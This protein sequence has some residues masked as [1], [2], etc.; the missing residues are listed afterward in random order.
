MVRVVTAIA[1]EFWARYR[2]I[3]QGGLLLM[4]GMGI[5]NWVWLRHGASHEAW[6]RANYGLTGIVLFLVYGCFHGTEEGQRSG[7]RAFP[8]RWFV[9][10]LRTGVLVAWPMILGVLSIVFVYSG[11]LLL[12][13]MPYGVRAPVVWPCLYLSA[14]LVFYQGVLWCLPE[15]RYLKLFLLSSFATVLAI[16]WMFFRPDLLAGTLAEWELAIDV[17]TF[18]RA[19][20]LGLLAVLPMAYGV[21]LVC[22]ARQRCGVSGKRASF[23]A[24]VGGFAGRV[25]R[26]SRP[27]RNGATALFW[28]EF[29]SYGL[30]LPACVGVVLLLTFV[31]TYLTAPHTESETLTTVLWMIGMPFV[32]AGVVGRGFAKP[33]FWSPALHL[34]AFQSVR[35]IR[36]GDWVLVRLVVGAVSVGVTWGGVLWVL[37]LWMGLAGNLL[38]LEPIRLFFLGFYR[39]GLERLLFLVVVGTVFGLLSWRLLIMGLPI[40]LSGQR[41]WYW[42]SNTLFVGWL[43]AALVVGLSALSGE[44]RLVETYQLW[45]WVERLP[46]ILSAVAM[47]KVAVG[48]WL[49]RRIWDLALV[50]RSGFLSYLGI[51]FLVSLG[52]AGV[53]GTGLSEARWLSLLWAQMALFLF[54]VLSPGFAILSMARNRAG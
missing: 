47:F 30:I 51:W 42:A 12:L 31:P 15:R 21:S 2:R 13:L 4:V 35:P 18:Q 32:L 38:G 36:P 3:A 20:T 27:Y 39:T 8:T 46:L 11:A 52:L 54:P 24:W 49:W 25:F 22:V 41:R 1:W 7:F 33:N 37:A 10:P 43:L 16:A 19:L 26:R 23:L 28:Y 34:P 6:M 29:R 5:A 9:L 17:R 53:A 48:I 40:G 44:D 14:G 50:S 45:P